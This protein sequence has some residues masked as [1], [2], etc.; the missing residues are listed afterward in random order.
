MEQEL[1]VET[2]GET[3]PDW[4]MIELVA[5][6]SPQADFNLL[7]WDNRQARIGPSFRVFTG[8]GPEPKSV[9]FEPPA[10]DSTI[11]RAIRFSTHAAP[12]KSTRKL[13]DEICSL[14]QVYTDL[15]EQLARLTAYS[16]FA[17]WFPDRTAMP[18]CVSIVGPK[19]RQGSQV[20]R[21]LSCLF[22]RALPL[23]EVSL[24]GLCSFPAGLCPALFLEQRE[25]TSESRK[26]LCAST[27][28][29]TFILWKGR[30]VNLRC[31][32]VVWSEDPLNDVTRG[33]GTI[34][35]PINPRFQS[36]VGLDLV[37]QQ[38][39]ANDLQPKLLMHR[40]ENFI[41]ISNPLI[42]FPEFVPPLRDLGCCLAGCITDAPE[43]REEVAQL[44]EERN[45]QLELERETD[46]NAVVVE[47][48][49]SLC[50]EENKDSLHVGKITE[51]AN[52]ILKRSGEALEMKPRSVGDK[53]RLLCLTT[54]RLDAGG[55]GILLLNATR[56]RIHQ[57]AWDYKVPGVDGDVGQCQ[58]CREAGRVQPMTP[59][60]YPS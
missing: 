2:F 23:G 59:A 6:E 22:R 4:N 11:R 28:Q 24:A 56:Q 3:F 47:A 45:Q 36:G 39:I 34:E 48:M 49:F 42:D 1:Y 43:L 30:P 18:T 29:D 19:S 14:L 16:V 46:L 32:T 25:L 10:V 20:F 58:Y 44:L 21:L 26:A 53:L 41:Q 57:L 27:A 17:S 8:P 15:P 7:F 52:Q 35:I 38:K 33:P 13:F 54:R 50:H 55:R 12:Y 60:A 31:A 37:T 40:L 9:V 5:G 51:V